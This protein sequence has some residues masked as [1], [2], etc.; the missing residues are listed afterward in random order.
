MMRKLGTTSL[1]AVIAAALVILYL[2]LGPPAGPPRESPSTLPTLSA[3]P[4]VEGLSEGEQV[5]IRIYREVSP[6]VVHI[7]ST[8]VG[9]DFFFNQVPQ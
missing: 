2:E 3:A 5:I 6:A 9:Y 4:R 7:T 8:A 1:T